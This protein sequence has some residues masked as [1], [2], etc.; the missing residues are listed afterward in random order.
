VRP[1]RLAA[2]ALAGAAAPAFAGPPYLNNDPAPTD[3][4]GWEIYLFSTGEGHRSDA[5]VDAGVEVNYGPVENVQVSATLPLS[6]SHARHEGWDSGTGHVELGVKYR[7][8]KDERSHFS[9]AFF[10]KAV[11]PTS[12]L[13]HHEKTRFQF[14]IWLG[15][16]FADGASLFGGGGYTV[17]P[18]RGKRNFWQAGATFTQAVTKKFSLGA[19]IMHQGPDS[20]GGTS[21]TR[22]GIGSVMRLSKNYGLL[23]S[24]GPTWADHRTGYH[25][26]AALGLFY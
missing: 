2:L 3:K 24:V 15:K 8:F 1:L 20:V 21:Q 14:P 10:P 25:F 16:D 5:D 13:G 23:A 26:Y 6:F 18:N 4:G 7:F 9:A 22:A 12:T 11:L 17:N 19:E